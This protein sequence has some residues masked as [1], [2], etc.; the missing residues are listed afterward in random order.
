[1]NNFFSELSRRN[2]FRVAAAYAIVGWIILQAASIMAP[3]MG[4]PGWAVSLVLYVLFIGFPIAVLLTWAFEMTPEGVKKAEASAATATGGMSKTDLGLIVVG[5]VLIAVGILAPTGGAPVN[6][7]GELHEAVEGDPD[8]YA[9]SFSLAVLPFENFSDNKQL[10]WA[11]DGIAEDILTELSQLPRIALAARNSSFQFKGQNK[12]V[13][14]IGEILNVRYVLEGSLREQ[15][16][17]LRITAQLIEAETGNHVWSGQF[18][19]SMDERAALHD[20]VIDEILAEVS[21][22]IRVREYERLA[23]L[24]EPTLSAEDLGYLAESFNLVANTTEALR[25]A[26][27][28]IALDP[29]QAYAHIIRATS[30]V[31]QRAFA[32]APEEKDQF[33]KLILDEVNTLKGLSKDS[34]GYIGMATVLMGI[35]ERETALFYANQAQELAPDYPGVYAILAG[36]YVQLGE[37]EAALDYVDT[38]LRKTNIQGV[39][40]SLCYVN[41]ADALSGL[42][43][44]EEALA[45]ADASVNYSAANMVE[46]RALGLMALVSLGRVDEVTSRLRRWPDIQQMIKLADFEDILRETYADQPY[47]DAR[48]KAG[49]A[50]LE[51]IEEMENE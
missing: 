44:F 14:E 25:L 12:D 2:V 7:T 47:I 43:R 50:L 16:D 20:S 10:G 5:A 1:M 6:N 17:N 27:K 39:L 19:P 11:A 40:V 33:K 21:S 38:C 42:G 34:F 3:A 45:A 32:S 13:R 35:G 8:G 41:Q 36:L 18:N 31:R 49:Q 46:G 22:N 23:L 29:K 28:A 30:L 37:Y 51:I 48:I 9:P 15:G 26:D 24:P 4:L